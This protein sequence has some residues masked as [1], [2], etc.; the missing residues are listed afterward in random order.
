MI[1]LLRALQELLKKQVLNFWLI[2]QVPC[3]DGCISFGQALAAGLRV[4]PENS[5]KRLSVQHVLFLIK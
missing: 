4:K 3:G 2:R 1:T 5:F